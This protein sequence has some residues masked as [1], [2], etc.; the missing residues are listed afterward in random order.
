[1]FSF[2]RKKPAAT[3]APA[4]PAPGSPPAAPAPLAAA[5]SLIGS[6]L[7]QP[8]QVPDA[9][10]VAP[11]RQGWLDRLSAGLRKTGS[12][13]SEVFTGGQIDDQLYEELE[14]ALLMADTGV[15]AT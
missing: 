8:M 14:T 1:M 12:S 5:P 10:G 3:P 4:A 2:F 7:V 6:A 11:A 15:K 9:T 13:L